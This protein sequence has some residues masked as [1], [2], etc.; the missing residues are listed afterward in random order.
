MPNLDV[1]SEHTKT[2]IWS[3]FFLFNFELPNIRIVSVGKRRSLTT[4]FVS[5][6]LK[7]IL[8][9]FIV[10]SRYVQVRPN[11]VKKLKFKTWSKWH[12][13][14]NRYGF[15][16]FEVMQALSSKHFWTNMHFSRLQVVLGS[17]FWIKRCIECFSI[18]S[19]G[20]NRTWFWTT[21]KLE[22]HSKTDI[23]SYTWV[24]R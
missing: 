17:H 16:N 8:H 9:C 15:E 5:S 2:L 6:F 18:I 4:N 11:R 10:T 12:K 21:E 1:N 3:A 24:W 7:M 20:P 23:T 14:T 22:K 19:V 13:K